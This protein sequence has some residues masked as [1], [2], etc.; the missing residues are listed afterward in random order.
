MHGLAAFLLSLA[1]SGVASAIT[2]EGA[3]LHAQKC[4]SC[5]NSMFPGGRGEQIYAPEFRKLDALSALRQR[6]ETCASRI[7]AGWFDEEIDAV[8][9]WLQERFYRFPK[10]S[11]AVERPTLARGLQEGAGVR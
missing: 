4:Q 5:H 6:V 11:R 9:A 3:D 10:S 2:S 1:L 7:N 8:T